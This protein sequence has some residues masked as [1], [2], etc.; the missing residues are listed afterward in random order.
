MYVQKIELNVNERTQDKRRLGR[1]VNVPKKTYYLA[2]ESKSTSIR[3]GSV[4]AALT[5]AEHADQDEHADRLHDPLTDWQ[6][7][8]CTFKPANS[9]LPILKLEHTRVSLFVQLP[10]SERKRSIRLGKE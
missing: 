2:A 4:P 1:L 5:H 10:F 3:S 9:V 7:E 8:Q 6:P